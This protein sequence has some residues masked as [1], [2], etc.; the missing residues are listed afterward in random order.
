MVTHWRIYRHHGHWL[1]PYSAMRLND[2]LGGA[3]SLHAHSRDA[4]QEG[5]YKACK[6]SRTLK[7]QGNE[8]IR[9]PWKRKR[10]RTTTWKSTGI[11]HK[12]G[13]LLLARARG[14]EPVRVV[15]PPW[16]LGMTI[17]AVR[18]VFNPK[19]KHYDW[20]VVVDDGLTAPAA[21]GVG[22]VAVDLGRSASRCGLRCAEGGGVFG[23]GVAVQGPGTQQRARY[24]RHRA[25]S[26][27]EGFASL[28]TLAT[29]EKPPEA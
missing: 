5:F 20:H 18:H 16:L 28:Q 6:T 22:T 4:A 12:D 13:V 19:A 15:L 26:L 10:F 9:Y 14:L 24:P 3:S 27:Y 8:D 7:K 17:L 11:R 21:P 23:T 29:G 2:A 1:S 25:G